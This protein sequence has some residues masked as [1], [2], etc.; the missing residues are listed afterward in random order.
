[1]G[2][3]LDPPRLAAAAAASGGL[4]VGVIGTGGMGARHARNL[5]QRIAGATLAGIMDLD[6]ARAAEVAA[7]CGGAAVFGDADAMITSDDVDALVI[8]SPDA[9]H[10]PLAL[11]CVAA[12]KPVLCEKPLA[13]SVDQALEVVKAEVAGGRRLIQLGFMRVYDRAHLQLKQA[14]ESGAVGR[15]LLFRGVHCNAH[16][17]ANP[18][19][20]GTA[21][22]ATNA[23]VHD[24]HSARWLLGEEVVSVQAQ[25]VP[26][27]PHPEG[28][29]YARDNTAN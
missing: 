19:F 15:P 29:S 10:A 14:L 13:P 22:V 9:T 28:P 12:G 8:A 25:A 7:E 6:Q 16:N 17:P 4:R 24:F 1:M 21:E 20:E 27:E 26:G 23:A 2:V 3:A 5:S 18:Y 11:A